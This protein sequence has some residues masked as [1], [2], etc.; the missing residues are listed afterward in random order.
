MCVW[1][2]PRWLTQVDLVGASRGPG[3]GSCA[4]T[5]Q[6]AYRHPGRPGQ[7]ANTSSGGRAGGS[8]SGGAFLRCCATSGQRVQRADRYYYQCFSRHE[9]SLTSVA[10]YI[11][12]SG[13]PNFFWCDRV[14]V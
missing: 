14:M 10:Y 3:Y 7:C 13:L 12:K 1:V 5:N 4:A 8:P 2:S 9:I 6:G 11:L